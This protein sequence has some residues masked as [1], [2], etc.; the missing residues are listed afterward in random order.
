MKLK[1][2]WLFDSSIISFSIIKIEQNGP[3]RLILAQTRPVC[4]TVRRNPIKKV[5]KCFRIPVKK[6]LDSQ[7]RLG[8]NF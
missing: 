1:T 7:R 4:T 3:K 8:L 6:R 5:K 2:Q